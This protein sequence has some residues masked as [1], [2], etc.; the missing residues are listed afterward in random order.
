[1]RF[2]IRLRAWL[3]L[4]LFLVCAAPACLAQETLSE[5][6]QRKC[7]REEGIRPEDLPKRVTGGSE[8]DTPESNWVTTYVMDKT[9]PAASSQSEC[10]YAFRQDKKNSLWTTA[11]LT[12]PALKI[13]RQPDG[14]TIR[15]D[16]CQGG[17]ITQ[18]DRSAE[19]IFFSGHINPSAGCTM[20]V[21]RSLK[22]HDTFYGWVV[23][24]FKDG[25]T[26]YEHSEVHWAPTHY[27][28]LSVYDPIHKAKRAI[29]P[30][31]P[32]QN[33]HTAYIAQVK[34]VYD[35]C[36]P[37]IMPDKTVVMPGG[38]CSP[39]FVNHHCNPELFDNYLQGS[40]VIND[41]SDALAFA[42]VF[43]DE[44][45]EHPEVIYVFRN[46]SSAQNGEYRE[47]LARD[48]TTRY[49]DRFLSDYLQPKFLSE[50]FDRPAG[51]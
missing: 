22:F 32:Y 20:V 43:N 14:R 37:K 46:V 18:I 27:V 3:P 40:V 25:R 34:A 51:K 8:L 24:Q 30:R 31:K 35:A 29:Y 17:S 9:K 39:R 45:K 26:I 13:S 28:E 36:C 10:F 11:K 48:L 47:F 7:I 16:A 23:G 2:V 12:W 19:F 4:F 6:L 21:T 42:T 1:M 15:V 5:L 50:L 33:V 38:N 49:G 41:G 44:T